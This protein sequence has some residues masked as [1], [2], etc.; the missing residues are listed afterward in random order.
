MIIRPTPPSASS[1]ISS[2]KPGTDMEFAVGFRRIVAGICHPDHPVTCPQS[3]K[4]FL[5]LVLKLRTLLKWTRNKKSCPA[6]LNK[7][8]LRSAMKEKTK[9]AAIDAV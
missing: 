2:I 8:L 6:A 7:L 3:K 9:E 4:H 5:N 1:D